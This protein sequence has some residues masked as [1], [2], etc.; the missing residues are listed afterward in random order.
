MKIL[1]IAALAA[2]VGFCGCVNLKAPEKIDFNFNQGDGGDRD[3]R[4]E[5]NG[6]TSRP[7]QLPSGGSLRD[8]AT[9]VAG[10]VFLGAEKGV[11]FYAFDTLAYPNVPIELAANLQSTRDMKGL[12]GVTVAFYD[13]KE[14]I[15]L[16]TTN[17]AGLATVQ[18]T[19]PKAGNYAFTARIVKVP[20]GIPKTILDVSPAPLLVA[21]RSKDEKFVV[22]DLDHTVVDSS[23]LRALVLGARPMAES[24]EVTNRIAGLYS[25]VYLTHRPDL[26]TRKSKGWL[27]NNGYPAGP[28]LVS[29]LR[30]A[31]GD[32]GK[33]KTAK[34]ADLRNAFA[35]VKIGIGDKL[36]D[37]QAYVD[38][39]LTAYLIPHYKEKPKDMRKMA[40]EIRRLRGRR[41]HVVDGWREIEAGIFKGRKFPP[42]AFAR[43]LEIRAKQLEED[44]K[45]RDKDD[46]DDDDD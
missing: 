17:A 46:D 5:G 12:A 25:I 43:R 41:L 32:S 6:N 33:F 29:E 42:E 14:L 27:T 22:I 18:W 26:L 3:R 37:A 20:Q 4:H 40:R 16:A 30:Q 7:G 39:G 38:N 44:E 15:D 1:Q 19:P 13:G 2:A 45:R 34:L 8:I 21:A 11:L 28:L 24:V 31:L 10:T 9:E 35:N 36:S 23:F